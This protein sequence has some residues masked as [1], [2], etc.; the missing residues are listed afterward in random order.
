[1]GGGNVPLLVVAREIFNTH[2]I[3]VKEVLTQLGETRG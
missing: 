1:V 3:D 2:L